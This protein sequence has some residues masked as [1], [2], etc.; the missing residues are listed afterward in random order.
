MAAR[1][2]LL[3]E[4]LNAYLSSI[5]ETAESHE[6][7][8]L[9]EMIAEG[10]SEELEFK[11]TLRWDT[12]EGRVNK[13]L[14]QV[15]FKTTAALANSFEG[16]TLLIGISDSGEAVGLDQDYASLGEADRDRFELHLRNLFSNAFGQ[17]FTSTKLKITFPHVADV[18]ICQID[19][20]PA[21]AALIVRGKDKSGVAFERLYVR[22]GNSSPEMPL[23]ELQM[24][25]AKR[26]PTSA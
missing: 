12:K 20:K 17:G 8:T 4:E 16:G 3:A 9:E 6:A 13:E 2:I 19:V 5:T 25:M 22:S 14:E 26:F 23:S 10:E 18:E 15:V 11:Q 24:F 1:R 7:I 21:D